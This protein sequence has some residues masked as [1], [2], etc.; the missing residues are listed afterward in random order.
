MPGGALWS[1]LRQR[2]A[3][4]RDPPRPGSGSVRGMPMM[5]RLVLSG[6]DADFGE[7]LDQ[8]A[9]RID[10]LLTVRFSGEQDRGALAL[11]YGARG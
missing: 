9:D 7:A 2:N 11:F 3:A 4:L 1:A 6:G 8:S 5:F 10:L